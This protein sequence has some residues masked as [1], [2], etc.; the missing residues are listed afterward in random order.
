MLNPQIIALPISVCVG[1]SIKIS[2]GSNRRFKPFWGIGRTFRLSGFNR[3]R[4]LT[5]GN[6]GGYSSFITSI[7]SFIPSL[8]P[9]MNISRSEIEEMSVMHSV[10]FSNSSFCSSESVSF[11]KSSFLSARAFSF[12]Y[13][14]VVQILYGIHVVHLSFLGTNK[15]HRSCHK[16]R[17]IYF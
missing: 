16:S 10:S 9:A 2:T 3:S 13:A 8:N 14:S 15:Y 6:R 11:N 4:L 7:I 5:R 12:W 17:Q 1:H